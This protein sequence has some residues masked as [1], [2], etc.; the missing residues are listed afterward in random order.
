MR[1]DC[2]WQG[3]C[4]CKNREKSLQTTFPIKKKCILFLFCF[5]DPLSLYSH[6]L[7][8]FF[9]GRLCSF[10]SHILVLKDLQEERRKEFIG[11]LNL[12]MEKAAGMASSNHAQVCHLH[13]QFRPE[14]G[15]V[16]LAVV[17]VVLQCQQVGL[18]AMFN[19]LHTCQA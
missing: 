19:L 8:S 4:E 10:Q 7:L 11:T 18:L 6:F 16:V 9:S 2:W 1:C 12:H 3:S 14:M 15:N 17:D 13:Q 5:L